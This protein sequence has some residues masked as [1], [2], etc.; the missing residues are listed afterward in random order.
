MVDFLY[1]Y[2]D[3]LLEAELTERMLFD[4]S[5]ADDLPVLSVPPLSYNV[6]T[7]VLFILCIPHLLVLLAVPLARLDQ[8]RATRVCAWMFWFCWH[9][10]F[11]LRSRV[12]G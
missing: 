2:Q 8:F 1:R 3:S 5:I 12:S 10:S 4:V 6:I 11:L 7:A 9:Y